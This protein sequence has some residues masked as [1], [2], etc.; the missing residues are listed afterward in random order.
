MAGKNLGNEADNGS[1]P[2]PLILA[3][4]E[5]IRAAK[6]ASIYRDFKGAMKDLPVR[7]TSLGLIHLLRF[8]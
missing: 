7:D 6:E 3:S 8:F 4:A 2:F 1:Q 5:D